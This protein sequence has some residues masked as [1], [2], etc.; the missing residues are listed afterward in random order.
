V[1]DA[2]LVLGT[3]DHALVCGHAAAARG[4]P[5]AGFLGRAN[6]HAAPELY[7]AG[8]CAD[9]A[10]VRRAAARLGVRR[11][12]A[13]FGDNA[14][15]R[16][17]HEAAAAAGLELPVL[18]HPTAMVDPAAALGE[19]AFVGP[20]A[21]IVCGARLARGALINSGAVVEHDCEI[22]EFAAVY[23]GAVLGGRVRIGRLAA[24]GLGATILP[25]R[26]IGEGCV[27]G[28]GAVVTADQPPLTIVRG[29]PAKVERT[30]AF[31]EPY[32]S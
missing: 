25:G 26:A 10:A 32:V 8:D 2:I 6:K 16:R 22:G 28:A 23:S 17:A 24:V 14:M 30:R 1:A 11:A 21:L 18:V 3:G 13:G 20:R 31:D 7:I 9:P 15:R 29:C 5:V 19:G 4:L 12:V 27:V